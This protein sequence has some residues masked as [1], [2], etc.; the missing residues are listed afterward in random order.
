VVRPQVP[1]ERDP[2]ERDPGAPGDCGVSPLPA[3]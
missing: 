2:D 1:D 3:E